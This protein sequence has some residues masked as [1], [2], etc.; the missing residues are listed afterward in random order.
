MILTSWTQC[1]GV[2][3]PKWVLRVDSCPDPYNISQWMQAST[4]L[5]CLHGLASD[6]SDKQERVYQCM[7]SS[8]LNETVEFCGR[9]VPIEAGIFSFFIM[10]LCLSFCLFVLLSVCL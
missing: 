2:N 7:P 6:D 10:S 8:F 4:F 5:N 3:L 9:S 1:N